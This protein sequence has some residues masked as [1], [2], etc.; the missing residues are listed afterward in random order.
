MVKS[1]DFRVKLVQN[2]V[3]LLTNREEVWRMWSQ[4]AVW[5]AGTVG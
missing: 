5:A 3:P 1:R 2:F 4:V